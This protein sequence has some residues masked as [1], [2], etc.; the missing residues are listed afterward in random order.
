M[1]K[2]PERLAAHGCAVIYGYR[3]G[4][5]VGHSGHSGLT[6]V[7]DEVCPRES[8]R[9]KAFDVLGTVGTLGTVD[10]QGGDYGKGYRDREGGK[11]GRN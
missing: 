2:K 3:S 4:A 9:R 1:R 6:P 10:F 7:F 8:L 11:Q 5:K